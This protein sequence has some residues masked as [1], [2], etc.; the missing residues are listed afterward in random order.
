MELQG[1][2]VEAVLWGLRLGVQVELQREV[3]EVGL[4]SRPTHS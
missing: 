4:E 1:Q 3:V 2:V